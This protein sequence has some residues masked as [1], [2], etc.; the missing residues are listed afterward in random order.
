MKESR[1]W[2]GLAALIAALSISNAA[3][4]EEQELVA[5][6]DA[7]I[8]VGADISNG[9]GSL[10]MAGAWA[11]KGVHGAR[12][13]LI[14]F[15]LGDIPANAVITDAELLLTLADSAVESLFQNDLAIHRL[16]DGWGEA[17]TSTDEPWLKAPSEPGDANWTYR[18]F[19]TV[20]WSEPG[21]DYQ[22]GR[23]SGIIFPGDPQPGV[24][25]SYPSRQM[26][27]DVQFWLNHPGENFG[28]ILVEHP[29]VEFATYFLA[30]R[31]HP[32]LPPPRLRVVWTVPVVEAGLSLTELA[33]DLDRPMALANAGDGSDRL[34]I[35]EQ[36]GLIR[37]YHPDTGMYESPFLDL[38]DQ[39]FGPEDG[40]NDEQGLTGLAFHPD[41][42]VQPYLYVQYTH[43][44]LQPGSDVSRV[45]RF[46]VT[47][48]P[49]AAATNETVILEIE[50]DDGTHLGGDLHF[51]PQGYLFIATG[52]GGGENDEFGHA[53]DVFSPKG[54]V[55][56]INVDI[57]AFDPAPEPC[58]DLLVQNYRIPPGNPYLGPGN[59]CDE[60][61]H[62]GLRNP[63]KFSFDAK[64]GEFWV[65]DQAQTK[66]G[67]AFRVTS[68]ADFNFGWSCRE[69]FNEF[70]DGNICIS[71]ALDPNVDYPA[72]NGN[73]A[74]LGGYVYH[75]STLSIQER[76]VYGDRC[77][78]RVWFAHEE[79]QVWV[80]D[81]WDNPNLI[82]TNLSGFG[83]DEHCE[84]Y[85]LRSTID[86]GP[87]ALYRFDDSERIIT[88]GFEHWKCH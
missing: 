85:L 56:R 6:K 24:Y 38:E 11:D 13:A 8:T 80:K 63:G 62:L 71:P 73:C 26:V 49:D 88:S 7:M 44:P 19:D 22:P 48:N 86:N 82:P 5:T 20:L 55:L 54:K 66:P 18:L 29:L 68:G 27:E 57:V 30:S 79:G 23:S 47:V 2:I 51:D 28:W 35:A 64:T 76:Y 77:S 65:S 9:S 52:D 43:R 45:S 1:R 87:G 36:N 37:I 31:E 83:L 53:Q 84:L 74:M 72:G 17:G 34:F 46:E 70:P 41:F 12:R 50:Q 60:I 58:N 15:D 67:H 39:V 3:L 78:G 75:G 16:L 42:P 59:G 61:L 81:L 33:G 32:D 25:S 4:P 21:G 10:M 69:G 14:Q 40:S